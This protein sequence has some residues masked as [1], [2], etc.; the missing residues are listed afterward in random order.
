M[1]GVGLWIKK[2]TTLAMDAHQ[3]QIALPSHDEST[4][5]APP[6][7]STKYRLN[8]SFRAVRT[9]V[10]A[11]TPPCRS[12]DG[13]PDRHPTPQPLYSRTALRHCV[14]GYRVAQLRWR[15]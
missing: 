12:S 14:R 1:G 3:G 5:C 9:A 6:G 8:R 10:I 4:T 13:D 11:R 7:A 2:R 15:Y